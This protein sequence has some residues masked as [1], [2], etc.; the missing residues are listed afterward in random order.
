MA[1]TKTWGSIFKSPCNQNENHQNRLLHIPQPWTLTAS[2]WGGLKYQQRR[3]G[4]WWPSSWFWAEALWVWRPV[5]SRTSH[6]DLAV[7]ASL[8]ARA[9]FHVRFE[10]RV[11]RSPCAVQEVHIWVHILWGGHI[12]E[13]QPGTPSF[14][15]GGSTF[16]AWNFSL[17]Q[18]ISWILMRFFV[19]LKKNSRYRRLPALGLHKSRNKIVL[20]KSRRNEKDK[21]DGQKENFMW[22]AW[23]SCPSDHCIILP[24]GSVI[25][26]WRNHS[27]SSSGL[28][29]M[30]LWRGLIRKPVGRWGG[31]QQGI[32]PTW[33]PASVSAL[34]LDS[35]TKTFSYHAPTEMIEIQISLRKIQP[36]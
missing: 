26:C 34:G 25:C 16:S 6:P 10:L 28:R 13:L 20:L 12:S 32:V 36:S 18:R 21:V 7:A 5:W 8:L 27:T 33:N 24:V 4:G 35:N 30:G 2:A 14:D 11:P 19:C 31:V 15:H 29:H 3:S 22:K 23:P 1:K 9:F 17:R